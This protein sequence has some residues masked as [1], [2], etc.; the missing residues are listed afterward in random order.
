MKI[1][2]RLGMMRVLLHQPFR[3]AIGFVP[4]CGKAMAM[5]QRRIHVLQR[6]PIHARQAETREM[7]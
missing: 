2:K 3:F 1:S 4:Y 6:P 7:A 5:R